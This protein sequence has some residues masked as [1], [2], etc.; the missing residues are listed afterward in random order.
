MP[1]NPTRSAA[2]ALVSAVLERHRAL[3]E[4]LDALPARIEPRDRAAAHRIAAAVLRRLGSIDAVLEPYLRR[5]PSPPALQA[6]RIGAAELLLLGTPPH[7]AVGNAVALAPKP[8]AGLV[9]AVLRKVATEGPAALEGLDA[10]RLDTPPWLWSA[11]HAAYGP[12]VRAIAEAHTR[13]APLDLSLAP[14]AAAPEGAELLPNGTARLPAGTRIT[15]IPGFA[16]GGFWAQDAAAS[17]PA[18]L[19]APRPGQRV[20]DLCAAPGGKT[21]QLVGMGAAVTA[22][23]KEAAR[24]NRLRENLARLKMEAEVVV[25]DVMPWAAERRGGFDSVLLDAPCTATGTIRR[26]PEV[27]HLRRVRDVAKL[28]ATQA[29]LLEA[30]AGLLAPGGRLVFATCSLQPEEGEAHLARAASLGLRAEP[31]RAEE[32]PGLEMALTPEGALR[33]RPDLWGEKGGMDGFFIARFTRD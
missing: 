30:A 7:A 32:V 21:A 1:L 31:V 28:A 3:D 10:A 17:L 27:P 26:H 23:E 5:E 12:K 6:L 2:F 25:A 24:A 13:P 29:A 14:G 33:T 19:L 20:A 15:E 11:W 4:A 22:V 18:R 9:N 16:D 8:F